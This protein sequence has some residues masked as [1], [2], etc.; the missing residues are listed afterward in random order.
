MKL[1]LLNKKKYEWLKNSELFETFDDEEDDE[2]IEAIYC[3]ADENNLELLFAVIK[4]WGVFDY[5]INFFENIYNLKPFK[6]LKDN[7]DIHLKDLFDFLLAFISLESKNLMPLC[8]KYGFLEALKF[9]ETIYAKE[10]TYIKSLENCC[11]YGH[12]ELFKYL[13]FKSCI[14][15]EVFDQ[16]SSDTNLFEI[17]CKN[18]HLNIV[19]LIHKKAK[20]PK[21]WFNVKFGCENFEVL[22]FLFEQGYPYDK[23]VCAL[24]STKNNLKNLKYCHENNF[25]WDSRTLK[26]AL[27]NGSYECFKYAIENECIWTP[28]NIHSYENEM[29]YYACTSKNQGSIKCLKFLK[30]IG[31]YELNHG[32]ALINAAYNNNLDAIKFILENY[33]LS[34]SPDNSSIKDF[35]S[36]PF[37]KCIEYSIQFNY[38]EIFRYCLDFYKDKINI[39]ILERDIL[40][41]ALDGNMKFLNYL[42]EKYNFDNLIRNVNFLENACKSNNIECVKFFVEK[43]FIRSENCMLLSFNNF[44]IVKYLYENNFLWDEQFIV[45]CISETTEESFKC[46][47]FA[48]DK[49]LIIKNYYFD[50]ILQKYYD[51][52]VENKTRDKE[53][54]IYIIS[55]FKNYIDENG[56]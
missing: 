7:F 26:N 20:P 56:Y 3:K 22:K 50:L 23:T 45:K 55:L 12:I 5:P 29:V 39:E 4:F 35:V 44:E 28:D 48:N 53:K 27:I 47:Q 10:N 9:S 2:E 36:Y 14:P 11:I 25:P 17:A 41:F 46:L 13:F 34:D 54:D 33:D 18:G 42:D 32:E 8:C 19:K 15:E 37:E 51:Y 6:Y 38:F 40:K 30:K 21:S 31:K 43:G 49:G 24:L 1:S 52:L 16:S